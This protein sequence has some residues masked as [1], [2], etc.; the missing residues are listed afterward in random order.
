MTDCKV[1]TV[2]EYLARGGQIERLPYIPPA[3]K[4][5]YIKVSS[6]V[7]VNLMNLDEGQHFFAEKATRKRK[8][9]EIHIDTKLI[10]A[11]LL[12]KLGLNK[13]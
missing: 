8:V 10:P 2:E 1:E 9:K 3:D 6:P 7:N 5:E 12:A 4:K 13:D 11:A